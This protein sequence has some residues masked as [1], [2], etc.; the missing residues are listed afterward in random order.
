VENE[1]LTTPTDELTQEQP[2]EEM[3][4]ETTAQSPQPTEPPTPKVCPRCD[5][6]LRIVGSVYKSERSDG[7]DQP[8]RIYLVQQLRCMNSACGSN[9][10]FEKRHLLN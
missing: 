9:E 7:P 6:D 4:E 3:P 1:A 8:D 10:T 5:A 2:A